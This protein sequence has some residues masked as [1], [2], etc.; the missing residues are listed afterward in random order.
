MQILASDAAD[1]AGGGSGGAGGGG[2][3]GAG[4]VSEVGAVQDSGKSPGEYAD[5]TINALARIGEA[6]GKALMVIG[7]ILLLTGN[8][9]WGL[10]CIAVG[11][12]IYGV[13]EMALAGSDPSKT[14]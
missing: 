12:A 2:I 9:G 10:G 5:E 14:L 11:A 8:I 3:G 1:S 7:V 6:V 13:S 4:G